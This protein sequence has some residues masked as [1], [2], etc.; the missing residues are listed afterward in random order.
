MAKLISKIESLYLKKRAPALFILL[1]LVQALCFPPVGLAFLLPLC[2]AAFVLLLTG[3][4]IKWAFR[5]GLLYG[6][7]WCAADLF[8]FANIFGTAAISLWVIIAF[9]PGFF[10]GLFVWIRKRLPQIPV[11]LL[12]PILWT[13]VEYF[14]SE[15]FVLNFGW[16]GLSYAAVNDHLLSRFATWFGCYGVTFLIA[17]CSGCIA[18][19]A[20]RGRK[21]IPI[22][23]AAYAVYLILYS[24][25]LPAPKL[26][27]PLR[28]RLVQAPS[29]DDEDKYRLSLVSPGAPVDIIVWP[30]YSFDWDVMRWKLMKAQ[31]AAF[32]RKNNAYLLFGAK[33]QFDPQNF[34]KFRNTAYLLDR[35]GNLVGT[36]VKNHTVHFFDDGIR[37]TQSTAIPTDLGRLGVGICF[38]MDYSDVARRLTQDGAEVLLVPNNDPP[39][40]GRIQRIQHRASFQMRA[41]ECGRWLAR[42]DV[43][44]GTSV[45]LPTGVELTRVNT[46]GPAR[47][48]ASISRLTDRDLYIR[49]GWMFG[50]ICMWVCV[51]LWAWG[52]AVSRR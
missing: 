14:R 51:G 1:G 39:N 41:L 47:L 35:S 29:E 30:E 26:V 43:A 33:D 27:N 10:A 44:G 31:L 40:W 50:P 24:I 22:A 48:D 8:W 38:D 52:I 4:E 16:L 7:A 34:K 28:V 25:P 17:L 45:A 13:G 23:A 36:H 46:T 37:G 21:G 32:A 3:L 49:G 11:W 42:S 6:V 15:P 2:V 19:A 12:A 5:L 18:D 20:F 9:F